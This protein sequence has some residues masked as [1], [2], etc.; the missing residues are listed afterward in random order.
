MVRSMSWLHRAAVAMAVCMTVVG[1]G[2]STTPGTPTGLSTPTSP[3]PG[4]PTGLGAP[5]SEPSSGQPA[6]TTRRRPQP[7]SKPDSTPGVPGSPIAYDS[8]I[9]GQPRTIDFVKGYIESQLEEACKGNKEKRCGIKVVPQGQED[10]VGDVYPNPVRPGETI[11]MV[12]EPCPEEVP[13]LPDDEPVPPD[14][15]PPATDEPTPNSHG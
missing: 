14:S 8:T 1:C 11:T 4:T 7:S 12:T 9:G 5:T 10:C 15:T 3:T 2:E 6:S 13:E